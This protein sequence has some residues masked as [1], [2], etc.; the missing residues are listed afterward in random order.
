MDTMVDLFR[1]V[2]SDGCL[3]WWEW[4]SMAARHIFQK[5]KPTQSSS[6]DQ[7]QRSGGTWL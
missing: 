3:W 4:I 2:R 6:S 1:I 7:D 5:P